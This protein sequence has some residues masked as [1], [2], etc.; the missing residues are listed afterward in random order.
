M[1]TNLWTSTTN[2]Y[3]TTQAKAF[4]PASSVTESNQAKTV[5]LSYI[6]CRRFV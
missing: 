6:C 5:T 4:T 1:T 3:N 2:P